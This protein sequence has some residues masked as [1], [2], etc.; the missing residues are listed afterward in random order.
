MLMLLLLLTAFQPFVDIDEM[1]DCTAGVM[2]CVHVVGPACEA[3][4]T[5]GIAV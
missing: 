5:Y 1:C 3:Y 4:A 2:F